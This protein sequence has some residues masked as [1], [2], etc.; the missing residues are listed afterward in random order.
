M[1]TDLTPAALTALRK[2][3]NAAEL[4]TRKMA[5]ATGLTSSQALVLRQIDSRD[6]ITPG[7]VAGALG[8][9]QAT[10]TNIVDKLVATGLVTRARGFH[11]KRQVLLQVTPEGR[12]KLRAA[13]FPLQMR[14]S[15]GY[16]R[17]PAWEQAMIL[18]ALER[19]GMLLDGGGTPV[20]GDMPDPQ[21]A[22]PDPVRYEGAG[23]E[24]AGHE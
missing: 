19:L 23:H 22:L 20:A 15:D 4:E 14:F 16:S 5:V 2:I 8:F 18:A 21:Q 3:L 12:E 11:D 24:G 10:I 1:D 9:G 17:L 6:G 7:A 13:P